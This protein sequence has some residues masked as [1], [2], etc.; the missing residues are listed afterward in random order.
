MLSPTVS[1]E[2]LML[3]CMIYAMEGQEVATAN[4]PGAFLQTGYDKGD[5]HIK[6]EGAMVTL[7]EEIDPEY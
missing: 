3:S 6:L 2:G 7:I 1:N 4:I 5:I